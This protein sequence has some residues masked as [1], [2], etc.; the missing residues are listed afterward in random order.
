MLDNKW[1]IS[2]KESVC[3]K[4]GYLYTIM[5]LDGDSSL[6]G[7]NVRRVYSK[8]NLNIGDFTDS[9]LNS[10]TAYYNPE[11]ADIATVEYTV[12]YRSEKSDAVKISLFGNHSGCFDANISESDFDLPIKRGDSVSVFRFLPKTDPQKNQSRCHSF[13][14]KIMQNITTGRKSPEFEYIADNYVG[15]FERAVIVG[16][17]CAGTMEKPATKAMFVTS[18]KFGYFHMLISSNQTLF[19]TRAGDKLLIKRNPLNGTCEV[20]RNITAD[21][22]RATHLTNQR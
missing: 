15:N 6:F 3:N 19:F 5:L 20:L 11:R 21:A 18:P 8:K 10:L 13:M 14:F 12:T 22:I 16:M 7:T 1:I 9:N 4:S 2:K 17:G